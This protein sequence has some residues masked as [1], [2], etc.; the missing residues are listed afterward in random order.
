VIDHAA[1]LTEDRLDVR[2]VQRR[3]KAIFIG[4]VGNLVE[5]YDF[6]AYTAFALYFAHSRTATRGAATQRGRDP[7]ATFLMRRSAAVEFRHADHHGRRLSR[8]WRCLHV[9]R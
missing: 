8:R 9:D 4:S 1:S 5:W 2:D 6:Y 3:I 7:A